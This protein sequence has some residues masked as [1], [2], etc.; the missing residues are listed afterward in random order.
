M[1]RCL[2]AASHLF[3][4]LYERCWMQWKNSLTQVV[5]MPVANAA[6]APPMPPISQPTGIVATATVGTTL[7]G[8]PNST[9]RWFGS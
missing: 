8:E 7:S 3:F 6:A 9:S 2:I 4:G 5:S 1:W